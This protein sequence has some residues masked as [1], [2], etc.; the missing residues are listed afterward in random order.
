MLS[1]N[2][3]F[4]FLLSIG[5]VKSELDQLPSI[6]IENGA[7]SQS[8]FQNV[9]E[10]KEDFK[11]VRQTFTLNSYSDSKLRE[12]RVSTELNGGKGLEY[13]RKRNRP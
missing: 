7:E 5:L 11:N 2:I 3:S 6:S 4:L 9:K 8:I 12:I 13:N 1:K 10:A